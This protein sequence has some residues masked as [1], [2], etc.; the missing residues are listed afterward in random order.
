V[1]NMR[2][3]QRGAALRL[4]KGDDCG[5]WTL[6]AIINVEPWPWVL[7]ERGNALGRMSPQMALTARE[8]RQ[9]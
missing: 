7:L 2:N 4:R 9:P 6:V 1:T 8:D 5:G 3:I